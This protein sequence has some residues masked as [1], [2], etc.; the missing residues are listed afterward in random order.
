[1]S[2][3]N[4][5]GQRSPADF[6]RTPAWC[7]DR[8]MEAIDLPSGPEAWW[9]EPC[10]GEGDII[11]AVN[12]YSPSP[13]WSV[14]EI[15]EECRPALEA[16][17]NRVRIVDVLEGPQWRSFDVAITNP[18]F[19]IAMEVLEG[20]QKWADHVIILERLNFLGTE[21]RARVFRGCMPDIYVIPDRVSFTE[22]GKA[23][24]IEYAWFH[25]GPLS[26]RTGTCRILESTPLS[27]RRIT[28]KE[29]GEHGTR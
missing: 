1:M 11:R 12:G 26:N 28:R 27:E 5:G 22:N 14:A 13:N 9:L 2:S 7:V 6:Y 17:T 21:K 19:S 4:R 18:P 25:W 24:S 8:L 23:D 10:A 15:R 20:M 3:T 16:L 29:E